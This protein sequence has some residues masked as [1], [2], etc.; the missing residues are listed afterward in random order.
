MLFPT[1]ILF[2]VVLCPT[3]VLGEVSIPDPGTF[4]VD[5][6][7]II[8]ASVERQL[9]G[10]LRELEQKTTAQ[11]KVLTVPSTD[12]EDVFTFSQRHAEMWKLGQQGKDN[13]AL[14]VLAVKER[15]VRF[16]TGYGLEPILPDSWTGS[17]SREVASRFF[18]QGQYSQGLFQL[19]V[20]TAN[21][22]ADAQ[23]VKLSGM[24]RSRPQGRGGSRGAFGA[25]LI[26]IL[27]LFGLLSMMRRRR[28]YS[29]WGVGGDWLEDCC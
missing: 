15:K 7:G 17:I 29:A 9:E 25:G 10:W 28:H 6:A 2:L 23:Q 3:G 19:V 16:Q 21:R 8:D 20:V 13:G 27:I 24:P 26:P 1:L 11:V 12:G 22:V 4:V 18:K 14:I 5:T